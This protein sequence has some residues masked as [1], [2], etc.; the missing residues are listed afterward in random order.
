M[1]AAWQT[2]QTDGLALCGSWLRV[3]L[4]RRVEDAVVY[5]RPG[6]QLCTV[7]AECKSIPLTV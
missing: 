6:W 4:T 5:Q 1:A 3:R 7:S 2:E